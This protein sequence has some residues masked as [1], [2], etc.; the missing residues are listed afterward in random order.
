MRDQL[1][2]TDQESIAIL[3]M[4]CRLPSAA[5]PAE[6]WSLINEGRNTV[7]AVP[8]NR[9]CLSKPLLEETYIANASH[10]WRG[11]FLENIADVDWRALRLNPR[12]A[13]VM[14]PQHRLL[15]ELAWEAMEDGG[16]P[17]VRAANSDACRT[18]VFIGIQWNDYFRLLCR[19]WQNLDGYAVIGNDHLFASNRISFTFDLTGPSQSINC[20]CASGMVALQRGCQALW[21]GEVDQVLVGAVD[22]MLA[23]DSQLAMAA[24]G[25]LSKTGGCRPL[26]A[27]ADGFVRGEGGVA[28]LLKP[29]SQVRPDERVHALIRGVAAAHGGRSD[30]IMA[31]PAA[32]QADVIRSA[33]EQA[34]I[35]P[36]SLE[37]VELHGTGNLRGDPV[38][39]EAL[40]NTVG[41][42]REPGQAHCAIGSVKAQIGHLGPVAG[43]AGLL[44]VVLG[45]EHGC[46]PRSWEPEHE[47]QVLKLKQWGLNPYCSG[48][49]WV[50]GTIGP[51]RAGVTAL[52]L[53][54]VASHAVVEEA[55]QSAPR[56]INV[57]PD[58][59]LLVVSAR[60]PDALV[61]LSRA[62]LNVLKQAAD[63]EV[64]ADLCY[65]AGRGRA[66]HAYRLAAI[67]CD[68]A[69]LA[70][71]IQQQIE[72]LSESPGTPLPK[73]PAVITGWSL[74]KVLISQCESAGLTVTEAEKLSGDE[75]R[76]LVL[77]F[78]DETEKVITMDLGAEKL[79][80]FSLSRNQPS[81]LPLAFWAAAYLE[82]A[83]PDF[84]ALIPDGRICSA[85]TYCW[86]RKQMWP[87]WLKPEYIGSPPGVSVHDPKRNSL[88]G[89][90]LSVA[91]MQ[92]VHVWQF[93]AKL[94]AGQGQQVSMHAIATAVAEQTGIQQHALDY[95][96]EL[97]T[98]SIA[99]AS[100]IQIVVT[101]DPGKGVATLKLYCRNGSSDWVLIGAN[102]PKTERNTVD[103][104]L[105]ELASTET[106]LER[107]QLVRGYVL[108][109]LTHVL[110]PE[111]DTTTLEF[112]P[113]YDL[114]M[115]SIAAAEI[116]THVE[117]DLLID[118]PNIEI[119]NANSS[120]D[121]TYEIFRRYE[122]E[123]LI[124]T[125]SD[126]DS[127]S[128]GT[129][130]DDQEIWTI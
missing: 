44:K 28:L 45:L 78:P 19:E 39:I 87:E 124:E 51:R 66:H 75:H 130:S 111:L 104:I 34:G 60:T 116:K 63:I 119:F 32:T 48:R 123:R 98:M 84:S 106:A 127:T 4:S 114:G 126:V 24:T 16:Y 2:T 6:F 58:G 15:L 62:Y 72:K 12:E 50:R 90:R 117:R 80:V 100:E 3:G 88:L 82:G 52:S 122:T 10:A 86:Q 65:T 101:E 102:A 41:E 8:D 55:P 37:Y 35:A 59:Y 115:D 110:Q 21:S 94:L 77:A 67:G 5:S 70:D 54:G 13:K 46:L 61:E 38:E 29:L 129:R 42:A 92:G 49:V 7:S 85:P 31:T 96:A 25:M 128:I 121:L 43:L 81:S 107:R 9:W 20:G 105:N 89:S 18:G 14:D 97:P 68:A 79:N 93:Q 125:I 109:L 30:W 1:K 120:A 27:N 108:R 83:I 40:G 64:V 91:G 103:F 26:D 69:E 73:K 23:P 56:D 53:G 76:L 118:L 112:V 17:I 33:C 22:L 74:E 47:N 11:C 36:T 99:S 57:Q 71:D 113:L 95:P